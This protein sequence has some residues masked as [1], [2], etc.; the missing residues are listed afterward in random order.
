[1]WNNLRSTTIQRTRIL[2][3]TMFQLWELPQVHVY[4]IYN[5]YNL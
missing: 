5:E 2:N 4:V 3:D 1:M